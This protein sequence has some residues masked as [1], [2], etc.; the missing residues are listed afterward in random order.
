MVKKRLRVTRR[1]LLFVVLAT[2]L[3]IIGI[4]LWR[5]LH[6]TQKQQIPTTSSPNNPGQAT[7]GTSSQP[8]S[9]DKLPS[10]NSTMPSNNSGPS[11]TTTKNVLTPSGAFVSNH[12]P[13]LSGS[14]ELRQE[15]SVCY[16]TAGVNCYIEFS[17]GGQTKTLPT[18]TTDGSGYAYWT[19]DVKDAGFSSGAWQ[20]KAV[21]GSGDQTKTASDSLTLDVQ[22]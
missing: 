15:Q 20:I 22:P 12:H 9:S 6:H 2:A 4:F 7:S 16:T 5:H 1:S 10:G 11:N 17:K 21:A 8:T 19:W 14:S 3:I 18:K 13:S